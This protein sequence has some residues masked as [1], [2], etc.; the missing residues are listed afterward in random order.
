MLLYGGL[1]REDFTQ[2]QLVRALGG[3][4]AVSAEDDVDDILQVLEI[5][6]SRL[7]TLVVVLLI[8]LLSVFRKGWSV[9]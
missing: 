7:V 2:G 1:D 8:L 4:A 5:L 3:E 9:E 6:S